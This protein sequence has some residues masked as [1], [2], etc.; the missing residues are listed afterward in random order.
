MTRQFVGRAWLQAHLLYANIRNANIRSANFRTNKSD[1][2][3]GSIE[4]RS[5]GS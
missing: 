1:S 5:S 2:S 4:T 3:A